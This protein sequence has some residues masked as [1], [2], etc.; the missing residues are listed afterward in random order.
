MKKKNE[1]GEGALRIKELKEPFR[2]VI[3]KYLI[4]HECTTTEAISLISIALYDIFDSIAVT[5]DT[6]RDQVLGSFVKSF[7]VW[8]YLKR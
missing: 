1:G 7:G 2:L 5:E 3:E 8:D 6:T 4:E